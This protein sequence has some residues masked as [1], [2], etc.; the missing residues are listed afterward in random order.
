[1]G[2]DR[3]SDAGS[4]WGDRGSRHRRSPC[5]R[6]QQQRAAQPFTSRSGAVRRRLNA[7]A[8]HYLGVTDPGGNTT[9]GSDGFASPKRGSALTINHLDVA[10]IGHRSLTGTDIKA[11]TP[12][13]ANAITGTNSNAF[14]DAG[15]VQL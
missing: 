8:G 10:T 14:A 12:T 7:D 9:R 2:G 15:S 13:D 3:C 1:V 4:H 11:V 5:D 6:T